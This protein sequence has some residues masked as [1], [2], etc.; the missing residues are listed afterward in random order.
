M[1]LNL[2][3][4][5]GKEGLISYANRSSEKKAKKHNLFKR[6]TLHTCSQNRIGLE[7]DVD[8]DFVLIFYMLHETP[9]PN[10]FMQ[11]VKTILKKDGKCLIVEPI[12]HVSK[13]HFQKI[14]ENIKDIGL[15]ILGSPSKKGGRSLLVSA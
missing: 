7:D 10:A 1:N 14:A 13:A 12:F 11:E 3:K 8:A 4:Y 9:D 2:S 5:N 6:I 15:K